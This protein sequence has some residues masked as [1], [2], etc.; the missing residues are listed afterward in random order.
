MSYHN[1]INDLIPEQIEGAWLSE[2][3][4]SIMCDQYNYNRPNG[5]TYH[6]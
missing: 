6:I 2:H 4:E 3:M 1:D 5:K